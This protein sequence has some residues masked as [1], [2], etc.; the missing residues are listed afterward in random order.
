MTDARAKASY[1]F[2]VTA[3]LL[4][5]AKVDLAKTYTTEFVKDAKVLP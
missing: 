4:D 3:K 5:P 2:L 1:D